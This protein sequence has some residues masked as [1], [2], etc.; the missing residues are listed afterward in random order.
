MG[1]LYHLTDRMERLQSLSETKRVVRPS[2]LVCTVAI[3]RFASLLDGLR[4]GMLVD[5][6]FSRIVEC[7]AE[8]GQHRN[9]GSIYTP[10][11]S[12]RPICTAPKSSLTK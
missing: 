7:D 10:N 11:G 8:E 5:V 6:D 9:P 3:S 1:P 2:C 4:M 12:R